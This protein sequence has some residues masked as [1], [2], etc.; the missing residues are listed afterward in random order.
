MRISMPWNSAL[1][2]NQAYNGG[3]P[4]WGHTKACKQAMSDIFFLMKAEMRGRWRWRGGRIKVAITAY[5][6]NSLIDAQNL[7]DAVSDAVELGLQVNDKH[8]DVSA[9]GKTDAEDP[10][11]V[12]EIEQEMKGGAT[13][14]RS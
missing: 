5:R 6:A 14:T 3:N 8:F 11:I 7:V 12:I 2:K 9:V 13:T 1:L 4:R 10:R